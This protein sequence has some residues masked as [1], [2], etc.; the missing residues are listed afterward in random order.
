MFNLVPTRT[1]TSFSAELLSSRVAPSIC[2]CMGF[3]L[4]RCRT[5]HITFLNFVRF[6]SAYF[7]NLSRSLWMAEL[8]TPPGIVSSADLLKVYSAPA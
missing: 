2:S 1:F 5:W 8:A 4:P 3:F 7:S 6:L